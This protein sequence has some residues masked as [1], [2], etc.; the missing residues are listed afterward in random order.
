MKAAT[1]KIKAAGVGRV[2]IG[3]VLN[4]WIENPTLAT[5]ARMGHRL[6][7]IYLDPHIRSINPHP[8]N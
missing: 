1:E 7:H 6:V 2:H 8:S 5:E 4:G 3:E